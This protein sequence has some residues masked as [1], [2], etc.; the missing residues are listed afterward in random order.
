MYSTVVWDER[1]GVSALGSVQRLK[2]EGV[3]LWQWAR[4][5]DTDGARVHAY[6][7]LLV[8][9]C[10]VP[11]GDRECVC[12]G[13]RRKWKWA[14]KARDTVALQRWPHTCRA[15]DGCGKELS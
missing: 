11:V 12:G 2:V 4:E 5:G 9:A 8:W 10:W 13:G 7:A 1:P 14:A 15:R 3:M 6:T